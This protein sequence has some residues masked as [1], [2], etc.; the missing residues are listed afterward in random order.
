VTALAVIQLIGELLRVLELVVE[1]R[2]EAAG[3]APQQTEL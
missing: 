1:K 2:G 3:S